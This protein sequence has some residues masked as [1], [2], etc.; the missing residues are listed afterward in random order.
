MQPVSEV[1]AI[2]RER[3][4]LLHT[5]VAQALGRIPVDA[6]ALNAD[7][8]ALT[9]HK[10]HGPKGI[11]A[12]YVRR[13]RPRV[14][15]E[16]L[17]HGGQH[18]RGLRSGTLASHQIV[19]FGKTAELGA[20][21]LV[22]G[23]VERLAALRDRLWAGLQ[24]GIEGISLNGSLEHRLPH[25]LN[26]SI[27][28]VE[29]NALLMAL[30]DIAVSSG[31]ACN[32]ANLAPSHVLVAIGVPDDAMHTSIRFGLG[33]FNTPEEVETVIVRFTEEV[34][35]LRAMSPLLEAGL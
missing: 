22:N 31:S 34:V 16:S 13:T 10:M 14:R 11:G 35:R 9:A 8:M 33:R 2:C 15:V 4:I 19:G 28:N 32:S 7:L 1:G 20:E 12:L 23:E 25:N 18:E 29:G 27:P 3:G 26:V 30:R 24:D 21:D 5:D 17:I 6:Q